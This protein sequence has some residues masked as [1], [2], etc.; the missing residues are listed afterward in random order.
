MKLIF[1]I[2]QC[3]PPSFFFSKKKKERGYKRNKLLINF[4][5]YLG[6]GNYYFKGGC[7]KVLWFD[8]CKVAEMMK[9]K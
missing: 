8:L 4:E 7:N 6:C 2:T 9:Q 1:K 5:S 3:S